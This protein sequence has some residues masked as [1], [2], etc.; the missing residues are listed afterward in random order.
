MPMYPLGIAGVAIML[1]VIVAR[2][3]PDEKPWE[4]TAPSPAIRLRPE[5][6]QQLEGEACGTCHADVLAEWVSSAHAISWQDE[7]YREALKERSRP[8]ACW[9][10]HAPKP[11]LAEGLAAR[12][13]ARS[14]LQALGIACTSCHLASDGSVL[15]PAGR[16]SSAHT[17]R[18]SDFMTEKASS[19]LCSVCHATNIGPVV[20][21][22]KD[23]ESSRQAERGRSCIGCHMQSLERQPA[24]TAPEGAAPYRGRSHAIQTPRD[25][26]FLARAFEI[27]LAIDGKRSVITLKNRAGHRVPGLIGREIQFRAE[28]L[29]AQG[30]K[31]ASGELDFDAERYLPVDQ[32]AQLP[33]AA[34]GAKVRIVGLHRDPRADAP[35]RFLER[36]LESGH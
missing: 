34:V 29:D 19:A 32:S 25:P 33:L 10:C 28:V 22:A 20:G 24:R 4:L 23:F 1:V 13:E 35:V 17:A 11:L 2:T 36:E 26:S 18:A 9:G 16:T 5:R 21:I 3:A 7:V 14:E 31:L 8:Q 15:G 12:A 6:L 27:T 30:Q